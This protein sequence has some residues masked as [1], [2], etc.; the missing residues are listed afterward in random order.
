MNEKRC[1]GCGAPFQYEDPSRPGYLPPDLPPEEGLVCRRCY[2]LTHYGREEGRPLPAAEA[3]RMAEQTMASAGAVLYLADLGDLE[4]SLPPPGLLPPE[5]PVLLAINKMDLLPPKAVPEE[6]L[7]WTRRRWQE[8]S[9]T[10]PPA[11]IVGIS[12][13]KEKGLRALLETARQVAGR[14]RSLAV[15]GAT[16]VGKSTLLRRLLPA[17]TGPTVARFPGTTQA[18]TRWELAAHGLILYDTPGLLPGDRL[19][20]LLCPSCAARLVPAR[21]LAGKLFRLAPGGAV[22]FGGFASFVLEEGPE[23]VV[24]LY[25]GE[26]VLLHRTKAAKAER[27]LAEGP[28]WLAPPRCGACRR[29]PLAPPLLVELKPGEDLAVA[30]LGWISLRGGPAVIRATIPAGVRLAKRPALFGPR[31]RGQVL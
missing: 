15:V 19:S 6:V 1:P 2:R 29:L 9:S 31:S 24:L 20:D 8:V 12:A 11:A 16:S 25:A 21:R 3:R 18:P 4:G 5:K 30:G 7:A 17:G 22:L 23:C 27:L 28:A 26:E 10:P 14:R 13:E